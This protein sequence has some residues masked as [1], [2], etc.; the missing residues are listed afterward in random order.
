[1]KR[2]PNPPMRVNIGARANAA[3][4]EAERACEDAGRARA[5]YRSRFC[6][7]AERWAHCF[8][9]ICAL[10]FLTKQSAAV[11][12]RVLAATQL[13]AHADREPGTANG[14]VLR[15]TLRDDVGAP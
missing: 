4:C 3:R 11:K 13:E 10:V 5:R 15:G 8:L 2:N 1:M 7:R 12:V 9:A 6:S 14:V